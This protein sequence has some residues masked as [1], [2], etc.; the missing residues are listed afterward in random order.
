MPP[1][2]PPQ[3]AKLAQ[4]KGKQVRNKFFCGSKWPQVGLLCIL[5]APM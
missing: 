4:R 1:K 2:I 3:V 5:E